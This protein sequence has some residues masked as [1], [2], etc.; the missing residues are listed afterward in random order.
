MIAEGIVPTVSAT[1][2]NPHGPRQ[3]KL[4]SRAIAASF[5]NK[6]TYNRIERLCDNTSNEISTSSSNTTEK[7][8][9]MKRLDEEPTCEL[10]R[11]LLKNDQLGRREIV[12]QFIHLLCSVN[13]PYSIFI[14]A[15]WGTGKTFFVKQ[16]IET[17]RFGNPYIDAN[18][19]SDTSIFDSN[20]VTKM[21]EDP[22]LPIYFNAWE[23]DHFNDPI[24]PL[25][26]TIATMADKTKV[27]QERNVSDIAAGAIECALSLKGLNAGKLLEAISG[28]DFLEAFRKRQEL[29]AKTEELV[30][31]LLPEAANKAV[32]FIDELDRCRPEFAMQ[33]LEQ[34]KS[35]FLQDNIVVVYSTDRTQ[36]AYSLQGVYGQ[37]YDCQ[38]YLQRFCD[39][40]FDLPRIN[41]IT[42]LEAKRV[43]IHSGYC[44]TK[45][46]RRFIE[47]N[48]GSLR[49]CNRFIDKLKQ[50]ATY[51]RN[52]ADCQGDWPIAFSR[53]ALL[54]TFLAMAE[55]AP[56]QWEQV[57]TGKCFD[58]VFEFAKEND[59]FM[60]YL[61]RAIQGERKYIEKGAEPTD[62]IRKSYIEDLCAEIF[63]DNYD[64]PR[65]KRSR[66]MLS[67][68]GSLDKKTL[69]TLTFP[70]N[71][72]AEI[73]D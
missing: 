68:W 58:R 45:I 44:F 15:P 43:D 52:D 61:D 66:E 30:S 35:L 19:P 32:L 31:A 2:D 25:L 3:C 40:R 70:E 60:E 46:S 57:K 64:D 67:I 56:E 63:L 21:N 10:A 54:P 65:L 55:Y 28:S 69:R 51:I 71:V 9:H 62:G 41:P 14:D 7:R 33:L 38:R 72:I 24:A 5:I 42:Y 37:N 13:G 59:K 1:R 50:G 16:I 6:A 36:L 29:R 47:Q 73:D 20:L 17:L 8:A 48:R 26:A 4:R 18:A 34:T 39:Y 23:N 27:N 12:A 11:E 53:N 49:D 22:F